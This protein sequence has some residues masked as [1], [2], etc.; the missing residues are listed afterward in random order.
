MV[1]T[2]WV[3]N[4]ICVNGFLLFPALASIFGTFKGLWRYAAQLPGEVI[5]SDYF[6]AHLDELVRDG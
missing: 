3:R 2:S 5:D 4:H 1:R 6:E